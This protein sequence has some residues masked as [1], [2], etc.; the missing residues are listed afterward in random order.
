MRA[1]DG[2]A[3]APQ[4]PDFIPRVERHQDHGGRNI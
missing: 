3:R 4:F 2:H 1:H